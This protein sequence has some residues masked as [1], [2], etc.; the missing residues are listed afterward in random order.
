MFW[1]S[2]SGL[3]GSR[4]VTNSDQPSIDLRKLIRNTMNDQVVILKI[5]SSLGLISVTVSHCLIDMIKAAW[6][7]VGHTCDQPIRCAMNAQV[8]VLAWV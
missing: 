4:L 3:L 8:V 6:F 1:F 2:G 5:Q 7:N